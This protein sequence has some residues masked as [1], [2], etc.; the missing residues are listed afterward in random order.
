MIAVTDLAQSWALA[1]GLGGGVAVAAGALALGLRH[2]IDWDHIAAITDITSSAAVA[3]EADERWLTSEPGVQL[4]DESHHR[5]S[6]E[7]HE[8]HEAGADA[9]GAVAR[10]HEHG[11]GPAETHAGRGGTATGLWRRQRRPLLLGTLYA[12]GH[13]VVVV[14]LGLLA[15]MATST[16]PDWIDP[17]MGRVVGATLL[18][19]AAYLYYSVYRYFQGGEFHM[20]SRWM[21]VFALVRNGWGRL[22][23]T[24]RRHPYHRVAHEQRQYGPRAAFGIGA[25]H[26][27][28]AETGTQ[29]LLIAAA[30]GASSTA[31]GVT[32]LVAFVVGV[33][34]AN[35]FVTVATT[36]GF[37]SASRRQW[38]YVAV[39]LVAATFSLVIGTAFLLAQDNVLPDLDPYFRWIGGPR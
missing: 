9:T 35:S 1:S 30:A 29:V 11:Y 25:I 31:T 24:L 38:V 15:L 26:G 37:I 8:A 7:T 27:I 2:G 12:L 5:L 23:A 33:L 13:G 3:P 20:R 6:V 28:G 39:G 19:L 36:A 18:L 16:L 22:A 14:I 4:T 34:I 17:I 32:A 10:A 21:L